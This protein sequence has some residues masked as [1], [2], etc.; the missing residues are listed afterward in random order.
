MS[1]QNFI[2]A[3]IKNK[4]KNMN[5]K[6]KLAVMA[7]VLL[8]AAQARATLYDL[9]YTDNGANVGSGVINVSGGVATSGYFDV[10]AGA[11]TGVWN[12]SPGTGSDS[13]FYWDNA[14]NSAGN[15]FLTSAGLLF[16]GT[17]VYAGNEINIWG[18]SADNYS[19]QG[20]IGGNWNPISNGGEATLTAV[21]EPTTII[22]G[23][24]MLLPFGASTLRVLRRKQV[25]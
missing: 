21:P 13:S 7:S 14:V 23:V 24:M 6:I 18:N 11:A 10:T 9:T 19:L 20:N 25:A 3:M 15:P 5:T 1:N 12:L 4:K 16:T 8:V 2:S 17:G 22:S